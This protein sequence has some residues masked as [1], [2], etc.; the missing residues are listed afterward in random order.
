MCT[1]SMGRSKDTICVYTINGKINGHHLCVHYLWEDQMTLS[2]CTLSI[3]R[4]KDTICVYTIYGKIK[5]HHLCVHY[6]WEDQRTHETT[7]QT[8]Q[9]TSKQQK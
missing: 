3:G 9:E 6:P 8:K 2:V 7:I 4:S 1:L 5:G